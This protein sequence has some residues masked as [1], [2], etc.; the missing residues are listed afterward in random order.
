MVLGRAALLASKTIAEA[1]DLDERELVKQI[2]RRLSELH[3]ERG[4]K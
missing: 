2:R 3:D 1:D 4:G